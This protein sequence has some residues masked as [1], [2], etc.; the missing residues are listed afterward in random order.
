MKILF[1][2]DAGGNVG[3]G[4]FCRSIS[5]AKRLRE[6]GYVVVFSFVESVFW[7]DRMREGFDFAVE[8]LNQVDSEEKTRRFI[9]LHGIDVYYVDAILEFSD[10]FVESLRQIC[11]VVFYQNM[12]RSA[13]LADVFIYPSLRVNPDFF[14]QFD[15]RSVIYRGLE[16][17]LLHPDIAKIP[18]KVNLH[19]KVSTVAVAAGGTD[20][21]DTLRRIYSIVKAGGFN[22][23][24]FVFFYGSDYAFKTEIPRDCPLNIE[25]QEFD[26]RSIL[27]ADVLLTAFGVSTYEFLCLGMPVIA[28]GH[29]ASNAVA[30]DEFAQNTGALV[31]LGEIKFVNQGILRDALSRLAQHEVREVMMKAASTAID[32]NGVDRVA[33]ILEKVCCSL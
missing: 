29:Q 26:H 28:Y 31:S 15:I 23:F 32:T 4:H 9:E 17:V 14:A 25:F 27:K 2:V 7:S 30:S 3:L 21:L 18:R 20:P 8:P 5:L 33:A 16:F 6:K 1:R 22:E 11:R 19:K 10:G 24:R 13:P 12:S